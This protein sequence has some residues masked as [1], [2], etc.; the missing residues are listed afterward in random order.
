MSDP[1]PVGVTYDETIVHKPSYALAGLIVVIGIVQLF[2]DWRIAAVF[3][4]SGFL[5]MWFCFARYQVSQGG[6]DVVVGAGWPH[7]HVAVAD[8][9]SV[10]QSKNSF[11]TTG[12]WGYRG[13]WTFL[14][15]VAI[16][17]GGRGAVVITTRKGKR[18]QLS[19]D[20]PFDLA[21]A[22]KSLIA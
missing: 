21:M 8:I 19:S 6:V 7:L 22:A 4:L 11:M 9:A 12:G 14:R 17:L 20:H 2:S 3:F 16:S 1:K 15:G 5:V 13:S 10:K 18:L